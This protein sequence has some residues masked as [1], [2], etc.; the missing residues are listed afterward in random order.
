MSNDDVC[1][2][3]WLFEQLNRE[4]QFSL[5]AAA[6][7]ENA[8]LNTYYTK[9]DDA[10]S[11]PWPVRTFCNPPYSQKAGPL[12]RWV[13]YGYEQSQKYWQVVV[14]LVIGDVSTRHREFALKYASEIRDMPRVKFV[15][16]KGKSPDFQSS[17]YVFRSIHC[18]KVGIAS[19]SIWDYRQ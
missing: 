5:D 18:R 19:V 16:E 1:T 13:E 9:Q 12:S 10:L 4:F 11:K 2:P 17:I 7:R 6:S 3:K 14:M 8:L 15:A